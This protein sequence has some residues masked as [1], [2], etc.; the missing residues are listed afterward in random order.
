MQSASTSRARILVIDD[1]ELV[2]NTLAA[3]LSDQGHE[4]TEASCAEEAILLAE[5]QAFDLVFTDLAMPGT[6]GVAAAG[7]LKSRHPSMKIVLMSGYGSERAFE[8][9]GGN[10]AIIDAVISKP[11]RLAEIAEV[12][13]EMLSR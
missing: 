4:V 9:A 11:F 6:D 1:Q 8:Q 3:L 7:H 10:S 5:R 2:R 13:K 12:V